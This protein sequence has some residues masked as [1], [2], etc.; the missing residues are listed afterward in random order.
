MRLKLIFPVCKGNL[1]F[2][3]KPW[4]VSLTHFNEGV[5]IRTCSRSNDWVYPGGK[6]CTN[7]FH[8]I[9]GLQHMITTDLALLQF[10]VVILLWETN[11]FIDCSPLLS[12][13]NNSMLPTMLFSFNAVN[14]CSNEQ[15][16]AWIWNLGWLKVFEETEPKCALSFGCISAELC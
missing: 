4:F 13:Q 8:V 1:S 2:L 6:F 5:S 14:T 12:P 15:V 16:A 10:N 3:F 7:N 9:S 11:S